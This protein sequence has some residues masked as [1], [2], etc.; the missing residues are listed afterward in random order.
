[1]TLPGQR[2][3]LRGSVVWTA[4]GNSVYLGSQYGM[5]MA[6]AKLGTTSL[7]GEFSLGLAIVSPVLLFSQM[8]LRQVLVTD[9]QRSVPFGAFFWT[10]AV[11]GAMALV[12]TL[13]A[14][15]L[16][17][18]GLDFLLVT[19][20]LGAAKFA[21]SQSDIVYGSLQRR[22]RMDLIAASMVARGLLG[23]GAVALAVWKTGTLVGATASLALVWGLVLVCVDLALLR[24][25]QGPDRL[26]WRWDPGVV[27]G[28]VR[29][30]APLTLAAGLGSLSASVPRYFLEYFRGRAA[31][32]LFAVA[33]M[34]ISLMG[35]FTGAVS[36]ATLPRASLYLQLGSL[37]AF[38]SL[39]RKVAAVSLLTGAALVALLA[40]AGRPLVRALFTS[41]YESVVPVTIVLGAG[42]A[43]SGLAAYGSTVL[44]AGRR[45]TLQLAS[46]VVGLL[47]Q[48]PGCILAIP[49]FGL[50]G[51]AWVELGRF[52]VTTVFVQAAGRS[53]YQGLRHSARSRSEWSAT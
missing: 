52:G 22:E 49:H 44:S 8:Q 17:G 41:E 36:Q 29:T 1:M 51:A 12:G 5:L 37:A 33:M 7:V 23:L 10:R 45:F 19:G 16:L 13:A 21:E 6:I 35:L 40:L 24:S 32:G 2:P 47:V 39:A 18:Y 25:G 28:L 14:V 50:S 43:L 3:S 38:H 53:V 26:R 48:V 30:S 11:A 15:A 34:P 31:V 46:V 42:V 9:A 4:V 27:R 20:L